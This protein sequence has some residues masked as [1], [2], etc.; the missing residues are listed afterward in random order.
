MRRPYKRRTRKTTELLIRHIATD[1]N[2]TLS[3]SRIAWFHKVSEE[4]VN[5]LARRMRKEGFKIP[6]IAPSRAKFTKPWRL[7]YNLKRENPELL[8]DLNLAAQVRIGETDYILDG[9]ETRRL[10]DYLPKISEEVRAHPR[11]VAS[12]KKRAEK[13]IL[14][15][16]QE[17]RQKFKEIT[18][19]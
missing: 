18:S 10:I 6:M 17:M 3:S 14:L 16:E 5:L 12:L 11:Y 7:I 13:K 1:L 9:I 2:K 19:S 15:E 4:W 8:V